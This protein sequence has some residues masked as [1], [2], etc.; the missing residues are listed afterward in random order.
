M[1]EPRLSDVPSTAGILAARPRRRRLTTLATLGSLVLVLAA[2]V[3]AVMNREHAWPGTAFLGVV[4]AGIAT[5][6]A[7]SAADRRL[8]GQASRWHMQALVSLT[9]MFAMMS[10]SARG[11]PTLESLFPLLPP[12]PL[13]LITAVARIQPDRRPSQGPRMLLDAAIVALGV[14]LL[15][16]IL[17]SSRSLMGFAAIGLA[18]GYAGGT[19]ALAVSMRSSARS[20][21]FGPDALLLYAAGFQTLF[22]LGHVMPLIGAL[23]ALPFGSAGLALLASGALA[24]SALSAWQFPVPG[25]S[26]E[27]AEDSR[28]RLLPALPAGAVILALSVA[29]VQGQG[30]RVGFFG[31]VGLFGLIVARLIFALLQNRDLLHRMAEARAFEDELRDLGSRLLVT[32][33][34]DESLDWVV[35]AAQSTFRAHN[36]LLWMLDSSTRELEAVKIL[37]PKRHRLLHRRMPLDDP[38]SLAARVARSNQG[39]VVAHALGTRVTNRFLAVLLHAESLLAVPVSHGPTVQG[40]LV[41]V[42]AENAEA[43]TERDLAKAQLLAAQV[44]VAIDNAYQHELQRRRLEE[45]TALYQFAQSAQLLVSPIEIAR[46]MLPILKAHLRYTY[47]AVWLRDSVTGSLRLAAGDGPGGVPLAGLRPSDLAATA[48]SSGSAAH[49]GLGWATAPDYVPPRSGVRSQLA[50]PLV[51]KQ[52]AVGVVDLES[53]QPNAYSLH[54]ERLMASIANHAALVIENL[55]LVGEARK[56]VALRELDQM[57]SNLLSTVSHELRTPLGSIKGYASMVLEHDEKLTREE[58]R[59]FV[60]V[61]DSEA[62]RLRE[63]I[64]NLLDLSRFEAGVMRI[65][66]APCH[67]SDVARDVVRKLELAS[68]DHTFLLDWP[69]DPEVVVDPRR[70]YQVMQNLVSNAVKYSPNGGPIV[71]RGS[72]SAR[73]ITVQVIDQGLGLPP[74]ELARVF[75]RF[76]RVSGEPS[77]KIGG[78]GLGLAICKA[79]VEAHG[80]RIWAESDGLD[81]GS[82]FT[83]VV[84]RGPMRESTSFTKGQPR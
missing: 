3:D 69:E 55:H 62:D 24:A 84:P 51:V 42:D 76:H 14:L 37:G 59:E 6:I 9:W 53:R 83:F 54:D 28:L 68:P 13:L 58:R 22:V 36:V 5:L 34:R 18:A 77:R 1:G 40:V 7:A 17:F 10:A 32:K 2:I 64:D 61:I 27:A 46:Q 4:V 44:A 66:P 78:T 16:D 21:L 38:D 48:Y 19:Y 70:L 82:C 8:D 67:L 63:L 71:V 57:K 60:E 30:T 20:D 43:Y 81:K 49:A 74:S 29:E 45:V 80:G 41:C 25:A 12:I 79:L 52:R 15:G 23:S 33:D 31:L 39:E 11:Q 56:V 65:D 26:P 47:A 50:V 72:A 73:E 35:Q 75:D